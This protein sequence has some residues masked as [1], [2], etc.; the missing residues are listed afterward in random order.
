MTTTTITVVDS[1]TL[2]PVAG[3]RAVLAS[4]KVG[5]K[6]T[7]IRL[8]TG[9]SKTFTLTGVTPYMAFS[10][11]GGIHLLLTGASKA[12]PVKVDVSVE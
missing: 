9:S 4:M 2:C 8:D 7:V 6:V 3:D 11:G 12:S 5:S 10:K 1:C